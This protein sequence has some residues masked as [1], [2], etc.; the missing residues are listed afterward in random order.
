LS[1]A[2]PR[3][4]ERKG[5]PSREELEGFLEGLTERARTWKREGRLPSDVEGLLEDGRRRI[6]EGKLVEG[7]SS[8]LAADR[9]MAALSPEVELMEYP[10]GLVGYVPRGERGAPPQRDEEQL[11]NR[12]LLVQRLLVVRRGEG[13]EVDTLVQRLNEAEAAYLAGDR[14]LARR[15]IDD[16]QD[17]LD[18]GVV[19][20]QS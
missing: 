12:L 14:A 17:R 6:L 18:A 16:V 4:H 3:E 20:G 10:R 8:L 5:Q 19:G 9:R 13:R 15:L 2:V 11:S 7:E 1:R